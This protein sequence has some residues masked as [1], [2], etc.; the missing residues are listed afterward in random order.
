[1]PESHNTHGT[2]WALFGH[3]LAI[4]GPDG[5]VLVDLGP[6]GA[7]ALARASVILKPG[8]A[9]AVTGTRKPTEIR[10]SVITGPDGLR[11]IID[12]SHSKGGEEI[13]ADPAAALAA[14][15][16]AGYAV[17][18]EARRKPK[19]FEIPASKDGGRFETHVTFAGVIRKTKALQEGK[20]LPTSTAQIG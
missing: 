8:D 2:I 4:E 18:G 17:E 7:E 10:A 9:I 3:R 6:E 16:S 20:A 13:P 11:R 1:M 12:R 5:R 15:R 14:L 19:H